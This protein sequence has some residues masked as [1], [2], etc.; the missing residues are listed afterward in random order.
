LVWL[1]AL[2]N[3]LDLRLRRPLLRDGLGRQETVTAQQARLT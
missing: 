1:A 3:A 2:L